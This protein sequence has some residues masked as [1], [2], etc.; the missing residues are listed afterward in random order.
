MST[1]KRVLT[2]TGLV[3][4]VILSLVSL[5]TLKGWV[6]YAPIL[7]ELYGPNGDQY[8]EKI[9]VAFIAYLLTGLFLLCLGIHL[10]RADPGRNE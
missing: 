9:I 5:A 10:D 2:K 8:S 3:F 7:G 4:L 1:E 6:R